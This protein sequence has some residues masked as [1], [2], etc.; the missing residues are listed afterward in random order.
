MKKIFKFYLFV[1]ASSFFSLSAI[2]L[3]KPVTTGMTLQNS[4]VRKTAIDFF[5]NALPGTPVIKIVTNVP[6]TVTVGNVEVNLYR[7]AKPEAN[8][9]NA[10][11]PDLLKKYGGVTRECLKIN[12]VDP[13]LPWTCYSSFPYDAVHP[14]EDDAICGVPAVPAVIVSCTGDRCVSEFF[15]QSCETRYPSLSASRA[16]PPALIPAD[17]NFG[18]YIGDPDNLQN[19]EFDTKYDVAG[20]FNTALE[21]LR[22][23]RTPI[24]SSGMLFDFNGFMKPNAANI[25]DTLI[26]KFPQLYVPGAV[27][28]VLDEPFMENDPAILQR[29]I[30][31]VNSVIRLLRSRIPTAQLGINVAP[32]W[33]EQTSMV[34]AMEKVIYDS[35]GNLQLQW[36]ATDVYASSLGVP[37]RDRAVN[38]ATQF[39]DYMSI[40]HPDMGKWLI[41][42]G[43]A[44]V[45]SVSPRSWGD[46]EKNQFKDLMDKMRLASAYYSGVMVWGWNSVSEL[47]DDFAGKNFPVEIKTLYANWAKSRFCSSITLTPSN[48]PASGG[49]VSAQAN[50]G[51]SGLSYAWTQRDTAY[52]GNTSSISATLG[53]NSGD[54]PQIYP[55]C[56]TATN[57]AGHQSQVCATLTVAAAIPA[58]PVCAPLALTSGSMPAAGGFASAQVNCTGSGLTYTWTLRGNTYDGHTVSTHDTNGGNTAWFSATLDQNTRATAQSYPVCVTASNA[59]GQS[60]PVCATWTLA[61]P[62]PVAPVCSSVTLSPSSLSSSGGTASA[63]ANCSGNGL[64]YLWTVNGTVYPGNLSTNSSPVSANT[65]ASP[66]TY[67]VCVTASNAGGQSQPACA[68]LTEAGAVASPLPSAPTIGTAVA[69]NGSISVNFTPGALG[70]GTFVKYTASCGGIF[71][72][73]T[74][75][76][77][78]VTGLSSATTYFCE[79]KTTSSVG[80]SDWSAWSNAVTPK[81]AVPV[82]SSVTLTPNSLPASG[83]TASAQANCS[84][85]GLSYVWTVN[86]AVYSGNQSTNSSPVSPNTT[87]SPITYTVCATASN[88]SGSSQPVCAPLVE[89]ALAPPVCSSVTLTPSSLPASG[90]TAAAQANCSG[91]GLTYAWTVNGTVYS[92]NQATNSSPVGTNTTASPINYSVCATASNTDGR[93]QPVCA[94][95]TQAAAAVALPS[96][97]TIGNAVLAGPGA[98]RVDFT[99]G[100]I[101]TGS[102]VNYTVSCGGFFATATSSPAIVTGLPAGNAFFCEVKTNSSV[103]TSP[104][105]QWSNP[106]FL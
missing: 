86:G 25:L 7:V 36:L 103:G 90:G 1:V 76:P 20:S 39:S 6:K 88:S 52:G 51:G 80:T 58:A 74:R 104:W 77:I 9:A 8:P 81:P 62:I 48:L 98:I 67:T 69:G 94:T 71:A 57:A 5:G 23:G 2:A 37:D 26:A 35:H 17:G 65:T 59:G 4:I 41:V 92:G 40:N 30:D 47:S 11:T 31:D 19:Q 27:I 50:C 78:V 93:S 100:A 55:V 45:N 46:A 53:A 22:Q 21:T 12:R 14:A 54:T 66:I 24:I 43:F 61:A 84:G 10:G 79:V 75:S 15:Y 85:S 32:I 13:V 72:T 63:Q 99:P 83:G 60:Q 29:K 33:N 56:V 102:F 3:E 87:N 16:Y 82:C 28:V 89:A 38:L 106:V 95:L 96:A 68:T 34:P 105:S 91:Y 70:T 18:N 101:G 97:P 64:T 42:Q 73:G 44:P 49:F